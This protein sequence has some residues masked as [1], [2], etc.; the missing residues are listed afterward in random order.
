[1]PIGVDHY[2]KVNA[3]NIS[4]LATVVLATASSILAYIAKKQNRKAN[5]NKALL[6]S[7]L[8]GIERATMDGHD[9]TFVKKRI[10]EIARAKGIDNP[11]DNSNK[12][13]T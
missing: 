13:L 7:V 11:L 4:N 5:R 10:E 8:R 6:D 2:Q 9:T 3:D 12:T 1:M